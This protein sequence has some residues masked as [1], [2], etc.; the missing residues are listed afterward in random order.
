LPDEPLVGDSIGY[1]GEFLQPQIDFIT[2]F[3]RP[4]ATVME[5]G[6]G[7]GIHSVAIAAAVGTDG[8]V[9]LYESRP[10]VQRILRQNLAANRVT[11]VTL[12]TRALSGEAA[13]EGDRETAAVTDVSRRLE[14]LDDLQLDRLDWVKL[15]VGVDAGMALDGAADTLWRLRPLLIMAGED[16]LKLSALPGVCREFSY[17][18]WRTDTPLFNPRN[19]NRRSDDIFS[20]R[21]IAS[22]LAIPEEI[23]VDV[24][25]GDWL[26]VT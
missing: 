4:G 22:L 21:R 1:Y 8:H 5:V 13:L 2:R 26:E 10:V 14:T 12:M 15:N 24:A 11:N 20:G 16:E 19:F 18:C 23:D 25:M 6:A 9:F 3:I 7:V 17:R